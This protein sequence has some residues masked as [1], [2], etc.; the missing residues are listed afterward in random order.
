MD[1]KNN[2]LVIGYGNPGRVDDG[3]GPALAAELE[4]MRL[5]GVDV[6]SDYQ[7]TVEDA[8]AAAEHEVVIFADA[9]QTGAEPFS[10]Q[11]VEPKADQGFS[12]HGVEPPAVM[13]M[14][15]ELFAPGSK[16]YTLGIRGYEFGEFGER[17][18]P[19]AKE[20]LAAAVDFLRTLLRT[21][22]FAGA[23]TR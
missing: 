3:L 1:A 18:S 20:N 7:L 21:R 13:A 15:H 14:A 11:A 22:E 5:D 9:D 16:G 12:T 6:D 4:S 23:V 19:R 10:F 2:I 8:A 17:L